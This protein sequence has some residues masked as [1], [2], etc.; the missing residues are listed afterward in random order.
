[1]STSIKQCFKNILWNKIETFS[2][3]DKYRVLIAWNRLSDSF[4]DDDVGNQEFLTFPL[5]ETMKDTS[6]LTAN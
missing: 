4:I 2:Q 6:T 3:Q 1:M 5:K